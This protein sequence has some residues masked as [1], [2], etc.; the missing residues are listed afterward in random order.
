MRT[1]RLRHTCAC[2]LSLFVLSASTLLA[3][4]TGGR[5]IGQVSDPSGAVLAGVQVTLVN[6]ASGVSRTTTTNE[7]GDFSFLEAPVGTYR[8]EFD[9]AGFKNNIRRGVLLQLNQVVTVNSPNVTLTNQNDGVSTL[10]MSVDNPG[11]VNL[12][13]SGASGLTFDLGGQITVA[14]TTPDGTYFGT[15]NVTVNY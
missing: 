4:S 7:S 5:F 9:L 10:L 14:S 1:P 12:G 8:F 11:T 3:Q 6:E 2:L 13:N 15:F